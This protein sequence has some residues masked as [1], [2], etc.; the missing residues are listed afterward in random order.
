MKSTVWTEDFSVGLDLLESDAYPK[1]LKT[2]L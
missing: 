2:T 1:S